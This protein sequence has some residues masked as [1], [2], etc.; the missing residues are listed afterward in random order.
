[1]KSTLHDP[2]K[3]SR[4]QFLSGDSSQGIFTNRVNHFIL[5]SFARVFPFVFT[6]YFF[7][8][9]VLKG[10]DSQSIHLPETC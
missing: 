5:N 1:M 8:W 2:E 4:R 10:V 6:Y 3:S 9:A 7:W